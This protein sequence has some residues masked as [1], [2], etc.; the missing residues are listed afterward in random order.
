MTSECPDDLD[1]FF[2]EVDEVEEEVKK[3]L[4][5]SVQEENDEYGNQKNDLNEDHN[6]LDATNNTSTAYNATETLEE[7]PSKKARH[8]VVVVSKKA[9]VAVGTSMMS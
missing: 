4:A 1:A 3:Q 7:H 5:A 2:D 6:V 9:I 8:G